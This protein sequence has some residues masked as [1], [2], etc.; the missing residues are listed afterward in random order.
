M[1][2]LKKLLKGKRKGETAQDLLAEM[3]AQS[4]LAANRGA[5]APDYSNQD[6]SDEVDEPADAG[7]DLNSG[8]G[9]LSTAPRMA[10][11]K[12]QGDVGKTV[13]RKVP[14]HVIW[15]TIGV[16]SAVVAAAIAVPIYKKSQQKS[17]R[18][19]PKAQLAKQAQALT[20][21][22][23]DDALLNAGSV[24]SSVSRAPKVIAQARAASSAALSESLPAEQAAASGPVPTKGAPQLPDLTGS[25]AASQGRTVP[26]LARSTPTAGSPTGSAVDGAAPAYVP[27][28]AELASGRFTGDPAYAQTMRDRIETAA[29]APSKAPQWVQA[30]MIHAGVGGP[31]APLQQPPQQPLPA[32]GAIA[33]GPVAAAAAGAAQDPMEAFVQRMAT[34]DDGQY[35]E[36]VNRRPVTPFVLKAGTYIPI[37]LKNG[38]NTDLPGETCAI[39]RR[40]V[41]DSIRSKHLLVPAGS[42]VCGPY[43]AQLRY[44]QV[45][46]LQVWS[47]LDFPNGDYCNLKGQ[48]AVD[49]AGMAGL[50]GDVD[51]HWFK[52]FSSAIMVS[53]VGGA[54]SYSSG[55]AA[56]AAGSLASDTQAAFAQTFG[57][58][59]LQIVSK[60]LNMQPTIRV[61]PGEVG[62]VYLTGDLVFERPYAR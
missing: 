27:T 11:L 54:L 43:Q 25:S 18:Q 34:R 20:K 24:P 13:S 50:T 57:A 21:S 6:N 62:S 47:R 30:A 38:I 15:G 12:A 42:Q 9:L 46:V 2:W 45:R 23:A 7:P 39:V 56:P 52:T 5:A 44:G 58:V 49:M 37:A 10:E 40:D 31:S 8:E 1:N 16:L 29:A 36:S 51:N 61:A 28:K 26:S 4:P 48:P 3:R 60:G 33:A 19:D 14:K 22:A 59:A 53:M 55:G 35:I 17:E 32:M 41:Y